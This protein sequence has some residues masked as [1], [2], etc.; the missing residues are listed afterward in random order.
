MVNQKW[1]T[2]S[3]PP[4]F[5]PRCSGSTTL[6]GKIKDG[7]DNGWRWLRGQSSLVSGNC[8]DQIT[9]KIRL[10]YGLIVGE[11]KV[12]R[13]IR[14][15]DALK[16]PKSLHCPQEQ[17]YFNVGCFGERCY[18]TQISPIWVTHSRWNDWWGTITL[19]NTYLFQSHFQK[20]NGKVRSC[21]G[22]IGLYRNFLSA[23]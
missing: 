21:N 5:L 11:R 20:E 10:I 9:D 15:I 19:R 16:G 14:K 2:F 6:T 13:K 18:V 7:L 1:Q 22:N 12:G 8:V 23:N 3:H 4:Q 17:D